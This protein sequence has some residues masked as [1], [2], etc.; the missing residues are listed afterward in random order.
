MILE[1]I[2][3]FFLVILMNIYSTKFILIFLQMK[4]SDKVV[5][6]FSPLI[7]IY[8]F[9]IRDFVEK[10]DSIYHWKEDIAKN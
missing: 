4:Y 10:N 7:G 5:C 1:L 3:F 9:I 8:K 6:R 2:L